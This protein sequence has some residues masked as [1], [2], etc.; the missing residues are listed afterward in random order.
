M[1]ECLIPYVK[2]RFN[3]KIF[4]IFLLICISI[5]E[6][7]FS[8]S[9]KKPIDFRFKGREDGYISFFTKNITIPDQELEKGIFGNSITRISLNPEGHLDEISIINSIDSIIDNEILRVIDLSGTLWKKIDTI[10]HNQVFYLQIVFYR[11]EYLPNFFKPKTEEL[12]KLFPKPILIPLAGLIKKS[13]IKNQELSEKVNL[14]LNNEE[15]EAALPFI[16]EL[17]KGDPFNRELYKTRIMINIRLNR[18][19]LVENDDNKIFNFAEGF[20]LAELFKNQNE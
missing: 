2:D 12:I 16:N 3:M 9:F 14:N 7:L 8:Q 10:K 13:F 4:F 11:S 19:E 20:S 17:I 1:M 5:S 15:F 18:P 6:S